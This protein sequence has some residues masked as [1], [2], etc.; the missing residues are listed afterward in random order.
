VR[1][2]PANIG[3]GCR[4]FVDVHPVEAVLQVV[5]WLR[6]HRLMQAVISSDEQVIAS[7][8][9]PEYVRARKA[10]G[11]DMEAALA[12][13]REAYVTARCGAINSNFVRHALG[14]RWFHCLAGMQAAER[15]LRGGRAHDWVVRVRPDYMWPFALLPPP[16]PILASNRHAIGE[17]DFIWIASRRLATHA[18]SVVRYFFVNRLGQRQS[19][20]AC[21]RSC[22]EHSDCFDF[23]VRE[24]GGVSH[25]SCSDRWGVTCVDHGQSLANRVLFTGLPSFT[26]AE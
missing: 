19:M 9:Q 17:N 25:S 26:P 13:D 7:P 18:L 21:P 14:L 20:A 8:L 22:N 6:E 23:A 12:R 5:R 10:P 15:K 1:V 2:A 24:A 3:W 4:R 16:S 11:K